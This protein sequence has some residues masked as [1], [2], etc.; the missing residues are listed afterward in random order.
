MPEKNSVEYN[1][2]HLNVRCIVDIIQKLNFIRVCGSEGERR[3]MEVIAQIL[4][5]IGVN[6]H[7]HTFQDKWLEPDD[8]HLIIN[9]RRIN[10]RPALELSFLENISFINTKK[11]WVDVQA[12]LSSDEDC[13]GKIAI[14]QHF[15]PE[16]EL[17][18]HAAARLIT[19]PFEP[20]MEAYLWGEWG[21]S[22]E[23]VPTAVIMPQDMPLIMNNLGKPAEMKWSVRAVERTFRNLVAEI[24]G[25]ERPDESVIMGAHMDSWPGT[26][27][28]SDDAA[29]CAVLVE[30]ARWFAMHP[31]ARTVKLVWF[32]GEEL[33]ARGSRAYVGECI[34]DPAT[35]KLMVCVDSGCELGTGSFSAYT[36][37][38]TTIEWARQHLDLGDMMNFIVK[39]P[40]TDAKAFIKS[41]IPIFAIEAPCK[42]SAHLP[43][44]RPDNLDLDKL[45]VLGT[46]SIEAAVHAACE[47]EAGSSLQY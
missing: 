22:E 1:K 11:F 4:D 34:P 31:P 5:E 19:C 26:V 30:A 38:Q 45:K 13:A 6:R 7:Y 27:G 2:L 16:T 36:S 43:D 29:G 32:T 21:C 47:C 14:T 44:D 10:V 12:V 33:D 35:V 20:E 9:D 40:G 17:D 42:Q 41:D 24:P 8:P 23:R 37:N 39:T 18:P 3:G 46:I 25:T 15:G 28:A